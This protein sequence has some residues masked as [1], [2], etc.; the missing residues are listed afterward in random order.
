MPN[1][2][3]IPFTH[4]RCS[5]MSLVI[6]TVMTAQMDVPVLIVNLD[7]IV[8]VSQKN[9]YVYII[10]FQATMQGHALV[11]VFCTALLTYLNPAQ[12]WTELKGAALSLERLSC[13]Q[14]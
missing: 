4:A 14:M 10:T 1:N 12:K 11:S 13:V 7:Y 6:I 8:M 3:H 2:Q 9:L 5:G